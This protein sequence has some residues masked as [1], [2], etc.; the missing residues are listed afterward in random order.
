MKIRRS[1]VVMVMQ[2]PTQ[3]EREPDAVVPGAKARLPWFQLSTVVGFA[4]LAVY[5]LLPRVDLR[6]FHESMQIAG[7]WV[8]YLAF[9]LLTL[10]GLPAT[11]FFLV[12][13]AAFPLWQ[14]LVGLVLGLVLHFTL[15][16]LISSRWLRGP[17][18]R[19][20]IKRGWNPPDV[21]P[22]NEW[23][24]A[25]MIKFAPGI[26]MFLKTY[27]IGVAGLPLHVMMGVSLPATTVYA[28]AFLTLGHTAMQG[29]SGWFLAGMALLVFV[30]AVWRFNTARGDAK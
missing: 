11:P 29:R 16:H 10:I 5:F 21:K 1:V 15:A 2:E 4:L 23:K 6:E 19:F 27:T 28:L 20:L 12:G 13:G 17:I 3:D 18:R 24:T 26:P 14:N 22:G 7:P 8:F 25:W 30:L 9:A